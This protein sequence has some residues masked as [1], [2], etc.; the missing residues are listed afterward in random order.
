MLL[1]PNILRANLAILY[2]DI[3]QTLSV[4]EDRT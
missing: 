3:N 2:N 4:R 1:Y